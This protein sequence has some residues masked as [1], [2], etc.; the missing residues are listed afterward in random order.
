MAP[1]DPKYR[2]ALAIAQTLRDAGAQAFFAGGCVRDLLLGVSPKD[3]DIATSA[4]PDQVV[5]LFPKTVAVGA[6]F[7]VSLVGQTVSDG[8]AVGAGIEIATE[9]ATFRNDGAY[10]DGRRRTRFAFQPTRAKTSCAATSPST[11]C[12]LDRSRMRRPPAT[13]LR[14]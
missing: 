9:V 4:T 3:Y 1:S 8:T 13:P 5:G 2:A 6:H 7:G 12:L 10:S 14:P 11:G